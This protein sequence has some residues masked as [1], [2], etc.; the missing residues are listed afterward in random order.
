MANWIPE[1]RRRITPHLVIKGAAEAI[2]FYCKAFGAEEVCRMP[3]PGPDGA[4]R[5]GHGEL[6]IGDSLLYVT[7][8]FPEHGMKGPDGPPPVTIHMY[9]PDVDAVFNRAIEAGATVTMPVANMFWGD[10]FGKLVDPFGHHW[11]IAT[12]IEDVSDEETLERLEAATS[13][14]DCGAA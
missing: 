2:D 1:G 6:R 5:L 14:A 8:E 11:S 10:R 3:M 12:H 13:K 7:D 4:V 9:V